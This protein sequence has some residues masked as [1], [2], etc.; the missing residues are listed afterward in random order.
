MW[1][2]FDKLMSLSV[3]PFHCWHHFLLDMAGTKCDFDF[4]MAAEF[5]CL[6]HTFADQLFCWSSNYHKMCWSVLWWTQKRLQLGQTWHSLQRPCYYCAEHSSSLFS[7]AIP[8][9]V[10]SVNVTDLNRPEPVAF[11]RYL[12]GSASHNGCFFLMNKPKITWL[13]VA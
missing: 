6:F 13:I 9:L 2:Y 5:S 8:L 10:A 7:M 11:F 12:F 4:Y 3:R 1:P